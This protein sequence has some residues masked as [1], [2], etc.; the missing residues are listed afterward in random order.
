MIGHN[1]AMNAIDTLTDYCKERFP[2]NERECQ[3]CIFHHN[4]CFLYNLLGMYGTD[5][6]NI[7][8]EIVTANYEELQCKGK[9]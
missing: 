1:E 2:G 8:R 4:R 6:T 3:N 9:R 5:V 7:A